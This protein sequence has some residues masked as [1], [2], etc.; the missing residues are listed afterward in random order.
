MTD[1]APG[2]PTAEAATAAPP[3]SAPGRLLVRAGDAVAGVAGP[4]AA[5]VLPIVIGVA[6]LAAG[7]WAFGEIY[8]GVQERGDLALLDRPALD[9]ALGLRSPVLDAALTALTFVGGTVITPILTLLVVAVLVVVRRSWTPAFVIVPAALGSLLITVAGKRVFGRARPSIADAVPPF[10]TSPSFP[11]GHA[12]NAI[13]IA[14]AVAYVLL[15]RRTTTAGR[16]WTIVLAALY[17]LVIGLSRVYLG[18]HWLTDVVAAWTIGA[19]WLAVVITAHRVFLV[20][21]RTR[22]G[23]VR[24]GAAAPGAAPSDRAR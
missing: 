13:V 2:S 11:S 22:A 12:L 19:A 23:P 21:R 1:P 5:Y 15:L 14:G 17:A 18:H 16:V 6:V 4:Y 3:R 10:E 24:D 8:E 7:T 9:L 20:V